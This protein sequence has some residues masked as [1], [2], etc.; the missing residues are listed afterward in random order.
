M[1]FVLVQMVFVLVHGVFGLVHGVFVLVLGVSDLTLEICSKRPVKRHMET[2]FEEKVSD[3]ILRWPTTAIHKY[4]LY[5]CILYLST[6]TY[7]LAARVYLPV[8]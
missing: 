8:Q 3:R 5:Y 6:Q 2:P 4:L 7:S 1:A